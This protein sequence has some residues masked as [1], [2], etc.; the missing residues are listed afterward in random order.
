[1]VFQKVP[2]FPPNIVAKRISSKS[3]PTIVLNGHLDTI[4]P[5]SSWQD[6]PFT[7]KLKGNMLYGLGA[8]DMKGGLAVFINVFRKVKNDRI[9][10][11]FSAT[12][13]EEGES[14]G[15]YAF[16][17]KYNGDFCLVG[18]PSRERIVLGGRGRFVLEVTVRGRAA[19]GARPHLGVNAIED[20]A[21]VVGSLSQVKIRKH[22]VLGEGSISPLK[23]KGG[24]DSLTTPEICRLTVDRH[25][26]MGET[27]AMIRKDLEKV[28]RAL[29]VNSQIHV[30]YAKRRTPFLKPYITDRRN[31]LVRRFIKFFRSEYR[32]QPVFTVAKSVGDYNAFALQMPTVVFGPIGRG[33]HTPKERVDVRSLYR[34][35]EFLVEYL[36]SL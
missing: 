16:L 23:I 32:K 20:M 1:M 28:V 11:T 34:C 3:A 6:D 22:R 4:E 14:T 10:L 8:S 19:Q 29:D 21:K 26:V 30:S 15:A 18:E 17:K 24:V 5:L 36:E 2:G 7:P 35:E 33:S 9:N 31:R 12:V 13:D 25:T 27:Q